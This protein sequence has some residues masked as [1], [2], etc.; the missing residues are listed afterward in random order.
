MRLGI[1][2]SFLGLWLAIWGG[3]LGNHDA[4]FLI[5]SLVF[6]MIGGFVIIGKRG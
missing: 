2:L 6:I 3:K 5:S 4:I 1:N